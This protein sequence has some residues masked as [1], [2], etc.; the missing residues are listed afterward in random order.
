MVSKAL[1]DFDYLKYSVGFSGERTRYSVRDIGEGKEAFS[2]F[3]KREAQQYID[4][5]PFEVPV[6]LETTKHLEPLEF[7]LGRV[8]KVIETVLRETQVNDYVG[9]ISGKDNFRDKLVTYYKANRDPLHKPE[10][11]EDIHNYLVNVWD[12]VIVDGIE[13]DD[14]LGLSQT[15]DTIIASID[16]D[17]DTIPGWHYWTNKGVYHISE[18][19]AL[20]F[21]YTQLL[22][23]DPTDNIK[24]VPGIGKV[25][26]H[27]A[28]EDKWTEVD[29]LGT[30]I[31]YYEEYYKDTDLAIEMLEE[32]AQLL[33]IQRKDRVNWDD[34][35]F[36]RGIL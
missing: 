11:F 10:Y 29:M 1:I 32:N 17:L 20:Q 27:Y 28:M 35:R 5:L 14:A 2:S 18:H 9:F 34:E 25:K 33:W 31:H 15:D 19:E 30:A 6:I 16:K 24:G 7:V 8:K 21:F 26:A 23:G 13:A 12:A 3:S 36:I 22:M 4:N